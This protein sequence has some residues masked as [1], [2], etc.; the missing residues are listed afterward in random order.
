MQLLHEGGEDEPEWTVKLVSDVGEG[1]N[2]TST[3][4]KSEWKRE[5]DNTRRTFGEFL[6]TEYSKSLVSDLNDQNEIQQ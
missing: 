1:I 6:E 2:I 4:D 3:V 5:F